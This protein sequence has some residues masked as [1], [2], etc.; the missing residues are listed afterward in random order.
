MNDNATLGDASVG[1]K[2]ERVRPLEI[3]AL[4]LVGFRST[5]LVFFKVDSFVF[6]GITWSGVPHNAFYVKRY[7]KKDVYHI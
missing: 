3:A 5:I 7:C 4:T 2:T 6:L 1:R